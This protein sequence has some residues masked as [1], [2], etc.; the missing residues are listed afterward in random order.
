MPAHAQRM[1]SLLASDKEFALCRAKGIRCGA[2]RGLLRREAAGDRGARSVQGRARATGSRE[3]VERW[4]REHVQ[5][6][7]QLQIGGKGTGRSALGTW[8]PWL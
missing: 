7:A 1:S 2:S 8:R 5:E 3:G 6:R 4:R